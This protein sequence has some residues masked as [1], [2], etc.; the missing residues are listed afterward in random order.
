MLFEPPTI[1]EYLHFCCACDYTTS[2]LTKASHGM[3]RH[4]A[5]GSWCD[6]SGKPP[7]KS[8]LQSERPDP[9]FKWLRHKRSYD[10]LAWEARPHFRELNAVH[11]HS[12]GKAVVYIM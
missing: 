11:V 7:H 12:S 2:V 5:N 4:K 8:E 10:P 3:P 1:K 6:G 9:D